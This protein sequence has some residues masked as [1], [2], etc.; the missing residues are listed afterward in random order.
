MRDFL[1]GGLD[2]EFLPVFGQELLCR[3]EQEDH[4]L[5]DIDQLRGD[6]CIRCHQVAAFGKI[7]HKER[8]G[9]NKPRIIAGKDGNGNA[10]PAV[11][12]KRAPGEGLVSAQHLDAAADTGKEAAE[13]LR[14]DNDGADLHAGIFRECLVDADHADGVAPA[15][16]VHEKTAENH[17][18]NG[19]EEADRELRAVVHQLGNFCRLQE[20]I[21]L[22]LSLG[23]I[24]KIRVEDELD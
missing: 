20:L 19:N 23:F 12:G 9:R 14:D 5:D 13:Q 18:R 21:R 17:R 16:A 15:G 6:L 11:A 7:R 22:N 4:A 10:R 1:L 24:G 3:E 2:D 8:R